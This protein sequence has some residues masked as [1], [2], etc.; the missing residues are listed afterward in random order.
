M[1]KSHPK[2]GKAQCIPSFTA[3]PAFAEELNFAPDEPH[4]E[5]DK[6][7]CIPGYTAEPT[8]AAELNVA[9]ETLRK[10]RRQG[11]VPAY[12]VV[13]RQIYYDDDDKPRWLKSLRVTPPRTGPVA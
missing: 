7:H 3:A 5:P 1:T 10:W 6:A 13:G 8:L 9:P 12:I 4:P 11:K 2:P